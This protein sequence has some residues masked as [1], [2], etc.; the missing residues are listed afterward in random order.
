MITLTIGGDIILEGLP[1]MDEKKIK[2][3]L[4]IE[5]Q[6]YYQAI[7]RNPRARYALSPE[8]RYWKNRKDGALVVP[9]GVR[10]R[11]HTYFDRS[12]LAYTEVDQRSHAPLG[13]ADWST[14]LELRDYQR[15]IPETVAACA[16]GV[17]ELD[18][19]FGKTV[20][21]LATAGLLRERT[22]V[23]VPTVDLLTQWV[24]TARRIFPRLQVDILQGKH[25]Y[26]GGAI[27]IATVQSL[28]RE[29]D[30]NPAFGT[31]FGLVLGD[32]CH[33]YTTAINQRILA[34][35]K[36]HYRYGL[37]ATPR[38][39]DGQGGAIEFIF[40]PVIVSRKMDR[41]KPEVFVKTY[42][43]HIP[44][45]EYADIIEEQTEDAERNEFIAR[46]IE[47]ELKENRRVLVLTKRIKHYEL[48]KESL[49]TDA[50]VFL[51]QAKDGKAVRAEILQ[52]IKDLGGDNAC[53]LLGTFGLLATGI[54]VPNLDTLVLAGDLKSDV[55]QVQSVGR[56]QRLFEGKKTPRVIDVVDSGNFI[57][58]RQGRERLNGYQQ[59]GWEVLNK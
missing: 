41:A 40:G 36:A 11:L 26:A 25:R 59:N 39:T 20:L 31:T 35:F 46:I 4:E 49:H 13:S 28:N 51:L 55:L 34:G 43:G 21:G 15:G 7:K 32:E 47:E 42:T 58:A 33:R 18:T 27:V 19:G 53:V 38:R 44:M 30:R 54:D 23:I 5:D 8:V 57:L 14:G 2:K 1:P 48:I 45:G 24:D 56:I 3:A 37:T 10:G 29:L 12:G 22:L 52:T 16:Q 17:L 9:R 50:P 6:S